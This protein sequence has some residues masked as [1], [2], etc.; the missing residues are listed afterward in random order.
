MLPSNPTNTRGN[1]L[2]NKTH[3]GKFIICG[4]DGYELGA[5][6]TSLLKRYAPSGVILFKRNI[7]N[8]QQL[9]KLCADVS[10]VL[11][12][13]GVKCPLIAID[14]E[15]WPV[16]RLSPLVT[17]FPS[18]PL[19]AA[20][21]DTGLAFEQGRV[22]GEELASLGINVDFAPVFDLSKP[23]SH[24][25]VALRSPGEE[26]EAASAISCAVM[27]GLEASGVLGCAKHFPGIA[28]CLVDPHFHVPVMGEDD[29]LWEK[30]D[31]IPFRR[32]VESGCGVFMVGHLMGRFVP[33]QKKAEL[34][35][36]SAGL[37]ELARKHVGFGGVLVT[38]DMFMGALT[39]SCSVTKA[40][41]GALEA[42]FDLLLLCRP[43]AEQ[44]RDLD[45]FFA[46]LESSGVGGAEEKIKRIDGLCARFQTKSFG[47][48]EQGKQGDG[49]SGMLEKIRSPIGV[50]VFDS[51]KGAGTGT[52]E[53]LVL[54]AR[55]ISFPGAKRLCWDSFAAGIKNNH[56]GDV[57]IHTFFPDASKPG[58]G[59]VYACRVAAKFSGGAKNIIVC[60]DGACIGDIVCGV[61]KALSAKGHNVWVVSVVKNGDIEK[62]S[63]Y[64]CA[65]WRTA[66]AD[67][68]SLRLAGMAI[69]SRINS[70]K[71]RS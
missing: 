63:P 37:V 18:M 28:D 49:V 53:M 66:S 27:K 15:G 51:G 32:A 69:W 25:V 3:P 43:I 35:T 68:A 31:L 60:C 47:T 29:R 57:K 42:G 22:M 56:P 12:Q 11:K 6:Q 19:L 16:D 61:V 14:H 38:D 54:R 30:P 44:T 13:A 5:G 67:A 55:N 26:P 9:Q 40:S 4:L 34:S 7:K 2:R 48:G 36:L 20:G 8:T 21:A 70:V 39:L 45:E 59:D 64:I 46:E 58:L 1:T 52:L 71:G 17:A 41:L 62:L 65:Y 50:P 33:G 24:P 10:R 23:N